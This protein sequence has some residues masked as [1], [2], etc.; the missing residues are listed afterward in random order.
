M[1]IDNQKT[2]WDEVAEIKTFTHPVDLALLEKEINKQSII[3]DFGC[4]YGRVVKELQDNGYS[5][6][7]G[8]DT[9]KELIKRGTNLGLTQLHYIDNP[10]DLPVGNSSVDCIFLFAV[11]TC[12]PTN[13][14]QIE[15]INLLRSKLKVGGII[16]ISDYYLQENP[17]ETDR[18][19]YLNN[20]KNNY[21]VFTLKEGV[22][23]RHHSK[24][25]ISTLLENF[26]ILTEKPIQV[27][28][29]NGHTARGFQII[30]QKYL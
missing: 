3:L 15:L 25:W 20:D 28:T 9:S 19:G 23:F 10:S 30:G 7:L 22:T 16:Y 18:Y 1:D 27:M 24:E 17:T 2:Y 12:I 11:L 8:F 26:K 21:G 5:N 29:M 6:V 14:A 13:A 4:G